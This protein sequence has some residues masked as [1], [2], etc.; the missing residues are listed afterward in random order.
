[1][2]RSC[3]VGAGESMVSLI[4]WLLS[5]FYYV[6]NASIPKGFVPRR[7]A[8]SISTLFHGRRQR[9]CVHTPHTFS[10]FKLS[11]PLLVSCV[12]CAPTFSRLVRPFTTTHYLA[13][14]IQRNNV[15]LGI[16]PNFS[17]YDFAL[18]YIFSFPLTN[19]ISNVK[20]ALNSKASDLVIA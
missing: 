12:S 19:I 14:V 9:N 5:M 8:N 3:R 17:V 4:Q 1:M 10:R 20:Y 18:S 7:I 13:N 2:V 16:D 15:I 6:C 11:A